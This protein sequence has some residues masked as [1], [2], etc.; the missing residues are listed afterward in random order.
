MI[1]AALQKPAAVPGRPFSPLAACRNRTT[2]PTARLR[3]TPA[4]TTRTSWF[5]A[6]ST[7]L[8]TPKRRT[9]RTSPFWRTP[10]SPVSQRRSGW[11]MTSF[12]L[13]KIDTDRPA[14]DA[15]LRMVD[16]SLSQDESTLKDDMSPSGSLSLRTVTSMVNSV[17]EHSLTRSTNAATPRANTRAN[18][19]TESGNESGDTQQ[20]ERLLSSAVCTFHKMCICVFRN[21]RERKKVAGKDVEKINGVEYNYEDYSKVTLVNYSKFLLYKS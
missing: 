9:S 4:T 15:Q 5:S 18:Y 20:I 21:N 13:N 3:P 6:C 1:I 14:F 19:V 17:H 10:A 7:S 12:P 16:R 11:L 8:L 2:R